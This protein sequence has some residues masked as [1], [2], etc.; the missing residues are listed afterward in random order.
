MTHNLH[1]VRNGK[2]W[3]VKEEG[4]PQPLSKHQTQAMAIKSGTN[5]AQS[6]KV[7]ILI[8]GLDGRIRERN[9]F[10]NDPFPPKG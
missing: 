5:I 8:H 6:N 10:G 1:V 4:H 2:I 3:A 9:S 7:E